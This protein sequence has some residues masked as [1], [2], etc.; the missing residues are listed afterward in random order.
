MRESAIERYLVTKCQEHGWLCYKFTSPSLRG[1]PDRIVFSDGGVTTLV[2]V[3]R[4][5]GR[6]SELQKV[7]RSRLAQLDH[8]VWVVWSTEDVDCLIEALGENS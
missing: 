1:V 4:E 6:L 3:K 8:F 7:V 5:N 2:E